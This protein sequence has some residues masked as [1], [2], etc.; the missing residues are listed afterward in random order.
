[1]RPSHDIPAHCVAVEKLSLPNDDV[2]EAIGNDNDLGNL[3]PVDERLYFFVRKGEFFE[4]FFRYTMRRFDMAAQFAVDL[5]MNFDQIIFGQFGVEG[6]PRVAK[7][8]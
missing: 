5:Y 1:M 4:I 3:F 7:D 6:G 8:G 2:D